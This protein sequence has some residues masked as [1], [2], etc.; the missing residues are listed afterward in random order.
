MPEPSPKDL[1]PN[2]E[3]YARFFAE[4]PI[5]FGVSHFADGRYIEVNKAFEV[6]FG[7]PREKIL[8]S[9]AQ[10]IGIWRNNAERAKFA[11]K[12]AR[13]GTVRSFMI[14]ATRPDGSRYRCRMFATLL[15]HDDHEYIFSCIIDIQGQLAAE[16]ETRFHIER[17]QQLYEHMR[18][19]CTLVDK[20]GRFT[21]SNSAFYEMLG[22]T[23]EEIRQLTPRDITPV[24]WH[25]RDIRIENEQV[26]VR[27]YSDLYEKEHRRKDGSVF[28]IE[29][30]CYLNRDV[31]GQPDGF[32]GLVRDISDRK[33][34]QANLN[35][36]A[37]HDPLTQLPN[38]TLFIDRLEHALKRA[39]RSILSPRQSETQSSQLQL[40]LLFLDLDHFKN[41]NDTMGHL[42]GD[43]LL[44][45]VA[46]NIARDLREADVLARI[47]GDEF[48][49]LLD[50]PVSLENTTLV[51]QRVLSLF[52]EPLQ[53]QDKKIYVTASIGISLFPR[54]GLDTSTLTKHADLAMFKAKEMGRNTY[55]FYESSL[56]SSIQERMS[57][58]TALRG[59]MQRDE[60]LLYYQPQIDLITGQLV[61]VEA[62]LRWNHPARGFVPPSQFITIAEDIGLIEKIGSWVL[63]EACHQ[64]A[65]WRDDGLEIPHIAV[66]LSVQQL[67]N[68]N[69][70][71]FVA[72]QLKNYQLSPQILELEVTESL[73]M[74]RT[75]QTL[76]I[77]HGLEALGIQLAIDD[78]GTGYSSLAYL[79]T[80]PLHR[81]KIDYSFVQNI[82]R[83]KNDEAIIRAIIALANSLNLETVA[84]GVEREEQEN[85]LRTEG[86]RISQGFRYAPPLPAEEIF[87]RFYKKKVI[88]KPL[89]E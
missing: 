18:D 10:E 58:E 9:T 4:C 28:P 78:F 43:L 70:V 8:S 65:R 56:G 36:L 57:I 45:L 24:Y 7:L 11:A 74:H 20:N 77:L 85:F 21:Q 25:E 1:A 63:T 5:P 39:K 46:K 67:K 48:V 41:I 42:T 68:K 15:S 13:H 76:A 35:F 71:D 14:D 31:N 3:R 26:F 32:W 55:C 19:G 79:K 12:L 52:A 37:Y 34:Q 49:I 64:M 62:L 86:C 44:Q 51:V 60:F 27:G 54:D 40:A 22:Y 66:N 2:N 53:V 61:G 23:E 6:V 75:E 84:E 83:D 81:L 47:G 69:L 82:G 73:L 59:A 50:S 16:E 38:R 88:G 87:A 30:Q 17:F 33:A 72:Q 80:L 89:A 29:L